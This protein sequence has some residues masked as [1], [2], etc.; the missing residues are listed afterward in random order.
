MKKLVLG[1]AMFVSGIFGIVGMTRVGM[2]AAENF[3]AV[4]GNNS[5]LVYWNLHGITPFAGLFVLMIIV[6]LIIGFK[7]AYSK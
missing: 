2:M 4:N 6:G 5:I 1:I 7:E 3:G